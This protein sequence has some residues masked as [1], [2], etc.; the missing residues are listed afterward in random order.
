LVATLALAV[1][2]AGLSAC[3][4][5]DAGPAE[6]QQPPPPPADFYGVMAQTDLGDEDYARMAQGGVG[7]L[8]LFL[9]WEAVD[10]TDEEDDF[11]F[12][13]FDPLI[14]GAARNGIEPL[15]YLSGMPEWAIELDGCELDCGARAPQSP[16]AIAAWAQFADAAVKRY[17][18]DGE[19]W[20]ENPDVPAH[21]VRT[22]QIWNEQNSP[23]FY[24]PEPDV[25]AFSELLVAA[26]E[27]IRE[28]DPGATVI[29]GG[30]FGSPSGG[31]PPAL[32]AV[33]FLRELYEID[34]IDE[35]FDGVAV[36]PYAAQLNK[37]ASQLEAMRKVIDEAGDDASLWVTEIGWSSGEGE[38]PLERGPEG[39]ADRLT[40]AYTL[41]ADNRLQ[42][43]LESVVWY[44]WRDRE[45]APVCEWCPGSGLFAEHELAP[46]P[47]WNAFTTFT[48]GS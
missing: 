42:W 12:A 18:P 17:G 36:H 13:V 43:D 7:T 38:N 35:R 2:A 16:E 4:S 3:G 29:L 47:A 14:E 26:E 45:S 46:K 20:R 9:P 8:R 11:D 31:E 24:A 10:P 5:D 41:F 22:W 40:E 39:Q 19:F 28:R 23:S 27:E 6:Q 30:M 25:E 34:G 44:S 15:V 32:T 33:E 48:G 37:V 21:P 1:A